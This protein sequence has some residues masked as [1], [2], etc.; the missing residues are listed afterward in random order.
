MEST[1]ASGSAP[2][3]E[4]FLD[5]VVDFDSNR[6]ERMIAMTD[7]RRDPGEAR[8]LYHCRRLVAGGASMVLTDSEETFVMKVKIQYA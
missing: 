8:I 2:D 3:P 4:A 6:Y 1:A 5:R 7:Y